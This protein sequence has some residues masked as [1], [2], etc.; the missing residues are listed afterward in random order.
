[1]FN[2]IK[3]VNDLLSFKY[4][5][6]RILYSLSILLL[7]S[8][9]IIIRY[10]QYPLLIHSRLF[11]KIFVPASNDMTFYN[12][13]LSF[14]AAY[15]F[16]I[17][18][19]YI[20]AT[21]NHYKSYKAL[22]PNISKELDLLQKMI[23]ICRNS[24]LISGNHIYIDTTPKNFYFKTI[25]NRGTCLHRFTYEVSY[26]NYKEQL[27]ELHNQIASNPNFCLLDYSML[28]NYYAI[29]TNDFLRF[30][31]SIAANMAA[32]QDLSITSI[33]ILEEADEAIKNFIHKFR[34]ASSAYFDAKVSDEEK[35][36]YDKTYAIGQYPEYKYSVILTSL[37]SLH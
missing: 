18:Q 11:E 22:S 31:D 6:N 26:K 9:C 36:K 34:L 24:L 20:P 30:M 2:K 25:S 35:M 5:R 13:A 10:C 32:S 12:I 16:Y 7:L 21:L 1:M 15:I 27:I 37:T 14:V 3:I 17:F 8:I 19:V 23:F 28:Y 29:P 4:A 33:L